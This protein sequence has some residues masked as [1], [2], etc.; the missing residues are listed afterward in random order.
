MNSFRMNT[1]K[2]PSPDAKKQSKPVDAAF[3]I[4]LTRGLHQMFDDVTNEP[5]PEE[6]LKLIEEDRKK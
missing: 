3:D 4:W 6:L 2:P 1:R 5:V